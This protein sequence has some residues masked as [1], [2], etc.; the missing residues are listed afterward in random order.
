MPRK[1]A[2]SRTTPV[3]VRYSAPHLAPP[4]E[5]SPA[6]RAEWTRAVNSLPAA[7]FGREQTAL[8][9]RFVRHTTRAEALDA[10]LASCDPAADLERFAKLSRLA[11]EESRIAL[12]LARSLR[13]TV[14]SRSH[15]VSAARAAA[16][17]SERTPEDDE[18]AILRLVAQAKERR[19][20]TQ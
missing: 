7:F 18:A 20:G 19:H 8:L 2:A 15:P 5:L 13:L 6:E 4:A 9:V 10:L 11:A 16:G 17:G 3:A 12:S 1:S 14:Q